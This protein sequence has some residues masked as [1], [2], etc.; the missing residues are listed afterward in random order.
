MSPEITHVAVRSAFRIS[1]AIGAVNGIVVSFP[2]I[3]HWLQ[4][5]EWVTG[6]E[7]GFGMFAI[8]LLGSILASAVATAVLAAV[9]AVVYN[10]VAREY[11]GLEVWI[12][13]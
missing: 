10:V 3:W 4:T 1:L 5:A 2:L 7:M 9:F 8:G 6:S 11:G 13:G 12:S